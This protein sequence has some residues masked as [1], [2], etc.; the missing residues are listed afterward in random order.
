MKNAFLILALLCGIGLGA[1]AQSVDTTDTEL[2]YVEEDYPVFPG[3]EDSLYR[4]LL[5]NLRYSQ[6]CQGVTG[7]VFVRFT[8]DKDGWVTDVKLLRG[9]CPAYDEEALRVVRTM[10]RWT[11]GKSNDGKNVSMDFNLPIDFTIGAYDKYR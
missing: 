7:K 6:E 9:L 11:P 8:V 5:Y 2:I 1:A 10:P 4:Y 3:G